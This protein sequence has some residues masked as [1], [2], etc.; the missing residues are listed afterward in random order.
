[1][2]SRGLTEPGARVNAQLTTEKTTKRAITLTLAATN[3]RVY[4]PNKIA[5]VAAAVAFSVYLIGF[6]ASFWLPEPK[7]E[8]LME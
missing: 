5:L 6:I 7:K 2:S 3:D 1:M 8:Q 4:A